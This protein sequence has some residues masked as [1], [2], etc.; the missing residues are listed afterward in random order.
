MKTGIA[1]Y[2]KKVSEGKTKAD[3][4]RLLKAA[5]AEAPQVMTILKYMY[6]DSIIFALPEGAP[7]FKKAEKR[8][9]LQGMLYGELR[10]LKNFMRGEHP[11]MTALR[12]EVLFTQL[13]EAL[14]P[15]DADLII[16][17]KDKKSPYKNITKKLVMETFPDQTVGW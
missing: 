14:D 9:D 13:L 10:K 6:K 8:E 16:A 12:R 17:M 3:R 15:D 11:N 4:Q 2:L 5:V 1:E 7:P